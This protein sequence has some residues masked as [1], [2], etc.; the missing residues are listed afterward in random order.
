MLTTK[1]HALLK[2]TL[3][4]VALVAAVLGE[5]SK[6]G[7]CWEKFVI[8]YILQC[9]NTHPLTNVNTVNIHILVYE[10]RLILVLTFVPLPYL[11]GQCH[12]MYFQL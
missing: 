10:V 4:T 3:S 11:F 6:L 5:C 7:Y 8:S 1:A 2:I 9:S 12:D